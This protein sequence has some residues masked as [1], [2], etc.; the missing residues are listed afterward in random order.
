MLHKKF[1]SVVGSK[2]KKTIKSF[3]DNFCN[4]SR[5]FGNTL[6]V[7]CLLVEAPPTRP[8]VCGFAFT[9]VI[10]GLKNTNGNCLKKLIVFLDIDFKFGNWLGIHALTSN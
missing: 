1:N 7:A 9:F 4:N 5:S 3:I 2:K 6:T 8:T 10:F